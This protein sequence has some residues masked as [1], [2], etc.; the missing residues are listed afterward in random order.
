MADNASFTVHGTDG[1]HAETHM[2]DPSFVMTGHHCHSCYELYY[3]HSGECRVLIDERFSDLH[4]GDFILVPPMALHYTRY[5]FGPCK[6][7]VVLFRL[8]DV[9]ET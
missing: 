5:V 6:R 8:E 3:V 9:P 4:A 1:V 2:R 7:T